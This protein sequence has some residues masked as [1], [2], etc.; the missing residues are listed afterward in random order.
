MK[1]GKYF[2]VPEN[3]ID[4]ER[5]WGEAKVLTTSNLPSWLDAEGAASYRVLGLASIPE[6][7]SGK[8]HDEWISERQALECAGLVVDQ[9]SRDRSMHQ[10]YVAAPSDDVWSIGIYSGS[11]P[12]DLRTAQD[13]HNPVLTRELVSD[14]PATFVADPFMIESDDIW[15]MFFE[16]MNW[17]TG[18]GEI[19]LAQSQDG[20]AWKY[21]QIVLAEPFHLSYPYVFAWEGE[22]YM[23]PE[24]YQAGAIRL[25]KAENF[26]TQWSFVTQ[27]LRG[28]YLV[29]PSVFR[30][31]GKWWLFAETNPEVKHDCLRLYFADELTGPWVEHPKSPIVKANPRIARPAGRVLVIGSQVFRHA[32]DCSVSYGSEVRG[33]RVTE[34][35]TSDYEEEAS[36]GPILAAS[37]KGWNADG[38]HHV[39][40]HRVEEGRWIACVDGRRAPRI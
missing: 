24:S 1:Q 29:D 3:P 12:F 26:P 17:Q 38:M 20:L 35:T 27:L 22:H 19:A 11:S 18:K 10:L 21:R 31:D 6:A 33:F 36:V 32:Q 25:Y 7:Q 40:A 14:V 5:L 4:V 37:G 9:D 39:D 34:L 16:V 13:A 30:Y 28:P 2:R 15:Y 8:T 23:I